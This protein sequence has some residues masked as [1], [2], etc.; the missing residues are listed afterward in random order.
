[1]GSLHRRK[2]YGDSGGG[3]VEDGRGGPWAEIQARISRRW[4]YEDKQRSAR[5]AGRRSSLIFSTPFA[6][7]F[8]RVYLQV[9]AESSRLPSMF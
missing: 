1:M 6:C 3:S 4:S 9:I 7:V 8:V 2:R 5:G